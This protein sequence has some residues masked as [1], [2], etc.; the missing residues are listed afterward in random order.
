MSHKSAS[1]MRSRLV[2]RLKTTRINLTSPPSRAA[3]PASTAASPTTCAE[4]T[5]AG[6]STAAGATTA[7]AATRMA[8]TAILVVCVCA[9]PSSC[10]S[11]CSSGVLAGPAV[12]GQADVPAL[13]VHPLPVRDV[14]AAGDLVVVGLSLLFLALGLLRPALR[15]VVS[16]K[17]VTMTPL[18]CSGRARVALLLLLV[19]SPLPTM[20][21]WR[22][23][24]HRPVPASLHHVCDAPVLALLPSP[25]L[26]TSVG[27]LHDIAHA[28]ES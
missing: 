2:G 9:T 10:S 1:V 11:R 28:L 20:P 23:S 24:S 27:G 13:I 26:Q 18:S 19:W 5:S 6:A 21:S 22:R 17:T 12:A 7:T 4:G 8:T 16:L 25:G 14:V 15:V 3:T